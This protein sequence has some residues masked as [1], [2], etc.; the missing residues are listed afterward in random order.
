[1]QPRILGDDNVRQRALGQPC[2]LPDVRVSVPKGDAARLSFR[3]HRSHALRPFPH[4]W[5]AALQ[6][7]LP[8]PDVLLH[9]WIHG[10]F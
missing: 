9:R 10:C 5:V 6:Q 8:H 1:M 3:D 2:S 7:L 4:Y